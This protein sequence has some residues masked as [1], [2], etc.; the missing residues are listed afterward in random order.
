MSPEQSE[1]IS[2]E[3][4]ERELLAAIRDALAGRGRIDKDVRE[5]LDALLC[6]T[7]RHYA[8]RELYEALSE[9]PCRCIDCNE[10]DRFPLD[11]WR[12][13]DCQM[14]H[15]KREAEA[16]MVERITKKVRAEMSAGGGK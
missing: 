10:L 3:E 16:M 6:T 2:W 8:P 1:P 12:C 5:R 13:E 9:P 14:K 15:E 7:W 4:F 11:R